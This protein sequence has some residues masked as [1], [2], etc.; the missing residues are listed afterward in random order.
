MPRPPADVVVLS[1][2]PDDDVIA[3]GGTIAARTAA[4]ADVVVVVV[5]DGAQ[6]HAAVLGIHDDPTPAELTGIRRDEARS[7][8]AVLGVTD[9]RFL[10]HGDTRL[11]ETLP[12]LRAQLLALFAELRPAEVFLPHEVHELHG[13]HRLTG[14]IAVGCLKELGQTPKLR[15]Y[16]VW[17]ERTEAEFAFTSRQPTERRAP[18]GERLVEFDITEHR[19][20][21]RAALAE[22][23][24]QVSLFAPGQTRP[25]VPAAFQRRVLERTTE[26]FWTEP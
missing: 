19:A 9:V 25:V 24:T 20:A 3:C 10:G 6:S 22:H 7:A 8:A 17:D 2:H 23:R 14:E 18:D 15:K 16:V 26:A 1:P 5:T 21:K 12:A 13:D 4:G 11:S